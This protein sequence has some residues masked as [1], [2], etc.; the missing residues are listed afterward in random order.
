MRRG[1]VNA[2]KDVSL[3][4]KFPDAY[5]HSIH[6]LYEEVF[7]AGEV[8]RHFCLFT[9]PSPS[10]WWEREDQ[11]FVAPFRVVVAIF[12]LFLIQEMAGGSG[13]KWDS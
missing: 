12:V 10:S 3:Q 4:V 6:Y 9:L 8:W 2:W 13:G 5:P 11:Y 7:I 1:E